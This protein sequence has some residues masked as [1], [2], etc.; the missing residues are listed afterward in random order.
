MNVKFGASLCRQ[1]TWP[2][3]ALDE[4]WKWRE[5]M[6]RATHDREV[7]SVTVPSTNLASAR[8][9][10]V[11]K[12]KRAHGARY[13]WTWDLER[14]CALTKP[15]Q[16]ARWTSDE[17]EECAWRALHVTVQYGGSLC[18]QH[19]LANARSTRV[20]K[21]KRAHG[22]R[23]TWRWALERHCVANFK[24]WST[25]RAASKAGNARATQACYQHRS[26]RDWIEAPRTGKMSVRRQ[27]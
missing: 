3:R 26:M 7:W 23:Y 24:L 2:M 4:W 6:A 27:M 22:A 16:C 15:G 14:D 21:M 18:C 17:I 1:Q 9:W 11:I 19:N 8:A 10:R 20:M 5:R 25:Q 13:T 12:M